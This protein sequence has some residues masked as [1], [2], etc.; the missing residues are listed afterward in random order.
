M[1]QQSFGQTTVVWKR[2]NKLLKWILAVLI[3]LFV[4]AMVALV[5]VSADV[6]ARNKAL[7]EEIL[8]LETENQSLEHKIEALGSDSGIRQIAREE[9]GLVDPNTILLQPEEAVK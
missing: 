2:S 1:P 6:H 8:R 3:V 7:E 5:W 9:L 4:A